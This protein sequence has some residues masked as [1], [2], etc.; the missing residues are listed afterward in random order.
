MSDKDKMWVISAGWRI[1]IADSYNA[2]KLRERKNT[3]KNISLDLSF[4]PL[5]L[6]KSIFS[7]S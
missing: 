2:G 7:L 6:I 4:K 5:K 3:G 1:V